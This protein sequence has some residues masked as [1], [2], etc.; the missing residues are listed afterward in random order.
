MK[1]GLFICLLLVSVLCL[2]VVSAGWWGDLFNN[3]NGVYICGLNSSLLCSII[4]SRMNIP[5]TP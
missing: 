3:D 5:I 4:N 1:R 2:S